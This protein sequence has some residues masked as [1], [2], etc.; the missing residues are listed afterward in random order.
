MTVCD[1]PKVC[2]FK[3]ILHRGFGVVSQGP[4]QRVNS[5]R[6]D[7]ASQVHMNKYTCFKRKKKLVITARNLRDR[8]PHT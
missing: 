7:E 5:A 6:S 1:K 8:K 3:S 4:V 2:G